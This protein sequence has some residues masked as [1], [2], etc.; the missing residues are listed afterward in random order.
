MQVTLDPVESK[1]ALR[2]LRLKEGDL[3]ELC[4]GNGGLVKTRL[5]STG[6]GGG[7]VEAIEAVREAAREGPQWHVAVACGSL[8]V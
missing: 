7:K 1:H 2:A 5:I 8:K 3:L 6:K 4:D